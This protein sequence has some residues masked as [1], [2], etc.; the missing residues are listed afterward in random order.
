MTCELPAAAVRRRPILRIGSFDWLPLRRI[1][2]RVARILVLLGLRADSTP[3]I[4][5][6]DRDYDHFLLAGEFKR[7]AD[8]I[9]LR[10]DG[11]APG[12]HYVIAA[13][14]YLDALHLAA[15]AKNSR[16]DGSVQPSDPV[17]SILELTAAIPE[18]ELE[19]GF[20]SRTLSSTAEDLVALPPAERAACAGRLRNI[21]NAAIR[22]QTRSFN[23]AALRASSRTMRSAA[24]LVG[25]ALIVG[26]VA[27]L[28]DWR[29]KRTDIS[30]DKKW[31]T[32]SSLVECQLVERG[33]CPTRP[34]IFFH[35]KQDDNPWIEYDLG[36]KARFSSIVVENARDATAD[37]AV[38]LILEVGDDQATWREVARITTSFQEWKTSFPPVT[39]RYARLRVPRSTYLHLAR[40][41]IHK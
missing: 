9:M 11:I 10:D 41:S 5:V 38:P 15:C 37:R 24:T 36:K 39:A 21:T 8:Q 27:L 6:S 28:A 7:R 29:E 22:D 40:V 33:G 34:G 2:P 26:L 16:G 23:Q 17:R 12:G 20:L 18:L 32:S 35:T 19:E 25:L 30:L 1:E 31:R 4:A 3:R 13:R 14:L